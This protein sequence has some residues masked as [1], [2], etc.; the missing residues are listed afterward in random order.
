VK[1]RA[2]RDGR[3]S[4]VRRFAGRYRAGRG[5]HLT[6]AMRR[7]DWTTATLWCRTAMA[8]PAA[9]Q[10]LAPRRRGVRGA[11]LIYPAPMR[12]DRHLFT[13]GSLWGLYGAENAPSN[14]YGSNAAAAW[15]AGKNRVRGRY[16]D[17]IDKASSNEQPVLNGQIWTNP[18]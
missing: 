2:G 17:I 14:Q 18:H 12:V 6:A 13:N 4:R 8:V 16:V 7:V 15:A 5:S 1:F 11:E 9:I 10:A 3:S